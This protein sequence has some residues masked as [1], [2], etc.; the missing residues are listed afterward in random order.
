[1]IGLCFEESNGYLILKYLQRSMKAERSLLLFTLSTVSGYL[2]RKASTADRLCCA[3]A[4]RRLSLVP[5]KER[6]KVELCTIICSTSAVVGSPTNLT[7]EGGGGLG[8]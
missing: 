2:S 7:V 8:T 3:S 6:A 1:M 5:A 4:A